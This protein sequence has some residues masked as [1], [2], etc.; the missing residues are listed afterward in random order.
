MVDSEL[1]T[2][3]LCAQNGSCE[4]FGG[5]EANND[6]APT[7]PPTTTTEPVPTT[8][9]TTLPPV[10]S[11]VVTSLDDTTSNGTLRWAIT[12]ANAQ[13]GGIYDSITFQSGLEGTITLTSD[14]PAIT[15]SVS[16]TGNGITSTI[17]D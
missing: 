14:L 15:E 7:L 4:T 17:I 10:T 12:Q 3:Q 16:I 2:T 5:V 8:T 11:L 13:S 6:T 9:T 1:G